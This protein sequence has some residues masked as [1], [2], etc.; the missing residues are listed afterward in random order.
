MALIL[1]NL[2]VYEYSLRTTSNV[3]AISA[4][5]D[6]DVANGI[7]VGFDQ[8]R[9]NQDNGH[10]FGAKNTIKLLSKAVEGSL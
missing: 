9:M 2:S 3:H 10:A 4:L 6:V 5:N 1:Y 7:H 8:T